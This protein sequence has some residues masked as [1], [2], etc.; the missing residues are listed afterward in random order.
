MA[1]NLHRAITISKDSEWLDHT[2]A[3]VMELHPWVYG[4]DGMT[5]IVKALRR[6]GFEVKQIERR[7]NTK[8]VLRKWIKTIG[9]TSSKLLLTIWKSILT[10]YLDNTSIQYYVAINRNQ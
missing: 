2:K 9:T 5:K 8:Y 10:V 6:K 4:V 7:I 1:L 3:L